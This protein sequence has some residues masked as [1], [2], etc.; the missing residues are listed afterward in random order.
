MKSFKIFAIVLVALNLISCEAI[1]KATNTTGSA[2]SLTGQWES[3]G[4]TPDNEIVGI[5][6]K[7][8]VAPIVSEGRITTLGAGANCLR[9]NDIV[10]KSIAANTNGGFTISNLVNGCNGLSYQPA[11][12]SIISNT[13]IKL[14]GKDLSGRD[15]TQLWKRIK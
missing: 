14:A 1:Q 9:Q 12:I 7:V 10:W 3:T 4:S 6:T 8:T 5:G 15:I 2:F 11:I 13:E